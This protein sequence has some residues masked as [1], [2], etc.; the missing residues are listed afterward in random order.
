[1]ENLSVNEESSK[2]FN[3]ALISSVSPCNYKTY[4][5]MFFKYSMDNASIFK[6]FIYIKS[7][8][9]THTVNVTSLWLLTG[10]KW[11]CH[12]SVEKVTFLFVPL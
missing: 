3:A 2:F 10:H 7:T 9:I 1:M 11:S 4:C 12:Y 8:L 5:F 6:Q